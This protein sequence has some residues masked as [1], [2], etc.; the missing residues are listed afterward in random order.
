MVSIWILG[1]NGTIDAFVIA[2]ADPDKTVP[3]IKYFT[4]LSTIVYFGSSFLFLHL[5]LG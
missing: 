3:L 4:I 2:R 1:L 5:G